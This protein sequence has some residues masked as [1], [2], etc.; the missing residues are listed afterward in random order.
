MSAGPVGP[1]TLDE[2]LFSVAECYPLIAVAVGEVE[3]AEG[4]IISSWGEFDTILEGHSISEPLGFYQT[5]RNGAG[6]QRPLFSG[7]SVF[8]TYRLGDGNFA[9]WY[10]ER[11]TN[12]GGEF[13]AGFAVPL[14]KDRY[15]DERRADLFNANNQRNEVNSNAN[16]R[17]LQFQRFATQAY[18]DWVAA[19]RNVEV[20]RQLLNLAEERVEQIRRRVEAGDLGVIAQIDNDR[21][22]ADRSNDLVKARRTFEKTA[23]KMSLFYR[24]ANCQPMVAG[25]Q[26]LPKQI[27]GAS[28]LSAEQLQEDIN[29]ALTIRPEIAELEAARAQACIDLRYA[30]NLTLPKL[31]MAGFASQ[32]IGGQAS[33]TGDK[34]PF[35][36]QVGF[37]AEVPI[38]RREGFGKIRSAQGKLTQIDAKRQFMM[39]KIRSELQDAAS[40]LNA[41]YQQIQL[42]QINVDLARRSLE[43]GN[44][45]F[46]AGDI[47]LIELNIYETALATAELTLLEAQFSYFFFEAIYETARSGRAFQ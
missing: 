25:N 24:D 36:L 29:M 12:E 37:N 38:Q 5:Y 8:G 6:V 31:D 15:I 45:L 11:E 34:T 35:E 40:A 14:V 17:L 4:K 9:P 44:R 13:R 42:S 30:Q 32:D 20:R 10:G 16:A 43:A 3:A 47:D 39:D 2:I 46:D 33:S 7:G 21:F 23:I 19:G 41:A 22:I 28:E 1:L 18:W 26:Q 27:P